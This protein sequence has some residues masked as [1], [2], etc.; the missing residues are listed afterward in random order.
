MAKASKTKKKDEILLT[1]SY[2]KEGKYFKKKERPQQEKPEGKKEA[3]EEVKVEVKKPLRARNERG[4]FIKN[5]PS[6][7]E[8]EAWIGGVPKKSKRRRKSTKK[9]ST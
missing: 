7:P 3:P 9:S 5:D 8:N 1:G 6:T 2:L 4:Q